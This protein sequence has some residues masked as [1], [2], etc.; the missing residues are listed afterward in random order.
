MPISVD[1]NNTTDHTSYDNSH[2]INLPVLST[3]DFILLLGTTGHLVNWTPPSGY[4]EIFDEAASGTYPGLWAAY[5]LVTGAEGYT[6]DGSDTVTATTSGSAKAVYI[7]YAISGAADPASIAPVGSASGQFSGQPDPPNVNFSAPGTHAVFAIGAIQ[8]GT[9]TVS[10]WPSGYTTAQVENPL[11][12]ESL[13]IYAC[14]DTVTGSSE[15]PGA[16]TLSQSLQ[17]GQ[18]TV[19]VAEAIAS[20]SGGFGAF[21]L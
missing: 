10:S 5:R 2:A 14:E 3:G 20:V 1:A 4:T 7:S 9:A 6:G 8:S 19:A 13:A 15:N 18:G 12:G 17:T 16:Y 11:S 21:G